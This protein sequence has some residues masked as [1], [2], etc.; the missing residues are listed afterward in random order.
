MS[1]KVT[2][3]E[4]LE[5]VK[6]V[7]PQ[8]DVS[9]LKIKIADYKLNPSGSGTAPH[10]KQWY[11]SLDAGKPDYSIYDGID[12]LAEAWDC[13][14]NYSSK[15]IDWMCTKSGPEVMAVLKK[16][17]AV[18]ADLGCGSG[19]SVY[20]LANTL[21]NAQIRGTQLPDTFQAKVALEIC[22][23]TPNAKISATEYVGKCDVALASE[24]FEH[25]E[26]PFDHLDEIM[27]HS[28]D[29][30]VLV[31]ANA[32]SVRAPG[33]F[34]KYKWNGEEIENKLTGRTFNTYLRSKGYKVISKGW[35][36]HPTCWI[37]AQ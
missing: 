15:Y 11:D 13:Y 20:Q 35:N 22:K 28:G 33:H 37:K 30:Q 17:G 6:R 21:P 8:F 1:N 23:N 4:Y 26:E 10:E 3:Q 36:A 2:L 27:M 18:I 7:D 29:P 19:M 12:Y 5:A 24:Y 9:T 31:L 16:P 34:N 25:F 32:F 14:V